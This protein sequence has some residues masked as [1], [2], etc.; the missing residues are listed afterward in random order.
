MKAES[1]IKSSRQSSAF[2][3][4]ELLV[5]IAIIAILA[6]MLLPALGRAKEK[7]RVTSCINNQR[8]IFLGIA[9]YLN[10]YN[11][12]YP[13]T[14]GYAAAGGP[15]GKSMPD[16]VKDGFV[17]QRAGAYVFPTNRPLNVYVPNVESWQCPSDKGD[18]GYG[19]KHC[20]TEFGNSYL[21]VWSEDV[22]R[23]KTV[24]AAGINGKLFDPNTPFRP[25]TAAEVAKKP[26]NKLIQGD[27]NWHGWH[28]VSIKSGIWHNYKG[29]KRFVFLFG[30]GHS[31]FMKAPPNLD[32]GTPPDPNYYWW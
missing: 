16:G 29:Q 26:D 20:F 28:D 14:A 22:Y 10:D 21:P 3:L 17:I 32:V 7:A 5:V 2:T 23:A 15:R 6:G 11:D 9:M 12:V 30:D 25:L 1:S 18:S 31:E 4:I 19:G 24:F 8:Q 27:W 13:I